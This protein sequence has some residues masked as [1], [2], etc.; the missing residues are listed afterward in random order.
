MLYATIPPKNIPMKIYNNTVLSDV[1][2]LIIDNYTKLQP[3]LEKTSL[4]VND[5]DIGEKLRNFIENKV[6]I[7]VEL[8]NNTMQNQ[9]ILDYNKDEDSYKFSYFIKDKNYDDQIYPFKNSLLSASEAEDLFI[10][11]NPKNFTEFYRNNAEQ[12]QN[13][14]LYQS[15]LSNFMISQKSNITQNKNLKLQFGFNSY[16]PSVEFDKDLYFAFVFFINFN[17]VFGSF[18]FAF[19]LFSEKK[20]KIDAML[21]GLGISKTTNFLCWTAI[22]FIIN[23]FVYI[24]LNIHFFIILKNNN[25]FIVS[26]LFLF[27][28]DLFLVSYIIINSFKSKNEIYIYLIINIFLFF[29]L[30]FYG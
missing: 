29:S 1:N 18:I 5:K 20:L 3:Y 13:F 15:L 11:I 10:S 17:F 4:I 21:N 9:I 27:I 30:F 14:V 19:Q 24:I 12:I 22:Y 7:I 2:L 26:Y 25:F 23:S 16:P 6:H 8:N 28:I